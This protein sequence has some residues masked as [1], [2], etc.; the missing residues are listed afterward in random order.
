VVYVLVAN[1]RLHYRFL[2]AVTD[3]GFIYWRPEK[4]EILANPEGEIMW[5]SR[6]AI[7]GRELKHSSAIKLGVPQSELECMVPRSANAFQTYGS[8]GF[9]HGGATLQEIVIP[10]LKAE[11]PRKAAKIPVV[12]GPI[13]EILSLSP[14][15]E[16]RAGSTASLPGIGADPNITGRNVVIKI[17]EPESGRRLFLSQQTLAVPSDGTSAEA[18][19]D[20]T[21]GEICARGTKLRIEVRDADNDELLD[22]REAEL[23]V[24]LTEWD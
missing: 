21:S 8:M 17:I 1:K 22:Q 13:T 6:R 3:H 7:V 5:R 19:L 20:R 15:V 11:W 2:V 10:V 9:F 24:D 18:S 14:R 4:D 12:L 16:I 23:K